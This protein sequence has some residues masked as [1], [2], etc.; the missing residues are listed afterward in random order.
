MRER[1]RQT[2]RQSQRERDTHTGAEREESECVYFLAVEPIGQCLN[3]E[4]YKKGKRL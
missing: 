3:V 4:S 1:E 2:D